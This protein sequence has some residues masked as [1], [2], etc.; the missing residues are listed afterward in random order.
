VILSATDCREGLPFTFVVMAPPWL[1]GGR[2]RL[3]F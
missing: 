1:M 3:S 2:E